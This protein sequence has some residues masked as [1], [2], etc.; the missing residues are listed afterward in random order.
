MTANAAW[1]TAQTPDG[2]MRVYVAR[3]ETPGSY[4]GVIVIQEIFGVNAHIQALVRQFAAEGFVAAAPEIYHRL[5]ITEVPYA[6]REGGH[7]LRRQLTDDQAVMD[8]N[9][10]VALLHEQPE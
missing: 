5:D 3:P 10:T 7:H 2:P 1:Q 4:P 6:D 9:A 8:V